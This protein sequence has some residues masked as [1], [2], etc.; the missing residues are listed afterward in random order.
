MSLR[1]MNEDSRI[2][3]RKVRALQALCWGGLIFAQLF[4]LHCLDTQAM[5]VKVPEK[6][7]TVERDVVYE[8]V[9][10]MAGIPER[11]SF[12][13]EDEGRTADAECQV[14]R[15][16]VIQE[17]WS[18]DFSFPVTFHVCEAGYFQLEDVMIPYDEEVPQLAGHEELL[19]ELIGASADQYRIHD[20]IWDGEIYRGENGELC[21]NA[22]ATGEKL[23]RDYRVHYEGTALFPEMERLAETA[24]V[25]EA[26]MISEGFDG[27]EPQ[28][29]GESDAEELREEF[30]KQVIRTVTLTLS[31]VL[32]IVILI[33]II[34]AKR[35][36]MKYTGNAGEKIQQSCENTHRRKES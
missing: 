12:T 21:R 5:M 7:V 34:L 6:K 32:L 29:L 26:A 25:S 35:R 33:M 27:N 17:W 24:T 28:N 15:K 9:E 1:K 23:L 22:I 4:L 31:L 36:K 11:M 19:L 13:V 3:L 18:D 16:V 30:W 2:Y 8:A 10:G 20:V 14:K